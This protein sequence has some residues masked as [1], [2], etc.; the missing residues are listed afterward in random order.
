MQYIFLIPLC[1]MFGAG[2][3]YFENR[4]NPS[5]GLSLLMKALASACFV[6]LAFLLRPECSDER[7]GICLVIGACLGFLGDVTLRWFFVG[8][9]FFF[10]GHAAYLAAVIPETG[11]LWITCLIASFA[12]TAI[13]ASCLFTAVKVK[14]L[15]A[16][17]ETVYLLSVTGT[18]VFGAGLFIYYPYSI[19][20]FLFMIGGIAFLASDIILLVRIGRNS[21]DARSGIVLLMLYYIAQCLIAFSVPY[22]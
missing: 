20:R 8:G 22:F 14:P 12:L 19:G 15:L 6:V 3:L 21:K 13:I 17:L 18:A 5:P 11:T 9:T 4:K 1:L 10:L 7:V 2:C 16:A